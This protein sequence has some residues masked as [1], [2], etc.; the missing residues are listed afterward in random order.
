VDGHSAGTKPS[1]LIWGQF[2]AVFY[3]GVITGTT[4]R[5]DAPVSNALLDAADIA[6]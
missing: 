1:R 6:P 5:W 2:Y 4:K 3:G